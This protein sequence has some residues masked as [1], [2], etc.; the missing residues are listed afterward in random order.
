MKLCILVVDLLEMCMWVFDGVRNNFDRI[1][2]CGHNGD[3]VV[4]L[5]YIKGKHLRSCRDGQLT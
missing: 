1:T 2:F 5:F 3:V 4:L